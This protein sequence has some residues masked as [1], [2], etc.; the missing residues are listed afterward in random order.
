MAVEHLTTNDFDTKV[1][2]STGIVLIDF[3]ADWCGPCKMLAPIVEEIAQKNPGIKVY[4]VNVDEENALAVKFRVMSIPTLVVFKD[5]E[6][7]KTSVGLVSKQELEELI[8]C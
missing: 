3:F 6:Q 2:G 5:G 4:K 7:I 1:A 8:N